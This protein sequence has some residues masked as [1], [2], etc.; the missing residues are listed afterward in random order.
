MC[1]RTSS[2]ASV[3]GEVEG[4][5][6]ETRALRTWIEDPMECSKEEGRT[7]IPGLNPSESRERRVLCRYSIGHLNLNLVKKNHAF[8]RAV[9]PLHESCVLHIARFLIPRVRTLHLRDPYIHTFKQAMSLDVP[10]N[11]FAEKNEMLPISNRSNRCQSKINR[12]L[13][14]NSKRC[15]EPTQWSILKGGHIR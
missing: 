12:A 14:W 4:L 6:Y 7:C 5:D 8:E 1:W 13:C 2:G 15:F 10:M 3:K 9:R 11:N